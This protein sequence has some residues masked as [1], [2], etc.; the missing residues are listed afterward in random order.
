MKVF[1]LQNF[2]ML[3]QWQQRKSLLVLGLLTPKQLS[4]TVKIFYNL[5]E[6]QKVTSSCSHQWISLLLPVQLLLIFLHILYPKFDIIFAAVSK[7]G[8]TNPGIYKM[9]Y[10][11]QGENKVYNIYFKYKYEEEIKICNIQ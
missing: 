3:Y 9:I 5:W 8:A 11:G 10:W 2:R 1:F 6:L 7:V 4:E